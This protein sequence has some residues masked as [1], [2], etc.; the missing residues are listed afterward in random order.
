MSRTLKEI[1]LRQ[2]DKTDEANRMAGLVVAIGCA[3][4]SLS[5]ILITRAYFA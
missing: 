1:R 4:A 2:Q 5:A 3:F